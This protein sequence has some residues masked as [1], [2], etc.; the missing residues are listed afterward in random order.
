[1]ERASTRN[2][3]LVPNETSI[4]SCKLDM[5]RFRQGEAPAELENQAS[6]RLSWS[7][8]LPIDASRNERVEPQ[9]RWVLVAVPHPAVGDAPPCVTALLN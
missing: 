1:M 5:S 7:F 3:A 2:A 6:F 8:A 9:Y 4:A